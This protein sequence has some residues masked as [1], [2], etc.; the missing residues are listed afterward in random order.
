MTLLTRWVLAHKPLVVVLWL[1]LTV[2]GFATA[3]KAVNALSTSFA[4]PGREGYDVSQQIAHQYGNGGTSN[5]IAAVIT[6][7][8][9][10][11]VD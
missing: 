10:T 2:V 7:P 11:T 3:G 6:L 8:S 4:L 1:V 5:P 9:G